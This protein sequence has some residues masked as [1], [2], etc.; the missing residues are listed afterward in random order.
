MRRSV[1]AIAWLLMLTLN[2]WLTPA[3][4][5]DATP[6]AAMPSA[7]CAMSTE[8]QN[9]KVAR[10]WYDVWGSEDSAV[11]EDIVQ[12]DII[13]HGGVG[14]DASNVVDLRARSD[15]FAVAFPDL[16]LVVEQVI[17]DGDYVA[18]RWIA[19][20][21]QDGPF[22]D[23]EPSGVE[24][25]WTGINIF[26]FECGKIAENWNEFDVVGLQAQLTGM[27]DPI[28]GTLATPAADATP[29]AGCAPTT[30]QDVADVAARWGDLWD[31]GDINVFDELASPDSVHHWGLG[32]DTTSLADFKDRIGTLFAGFSDL[33]QTNE[34]PIVDGDL[35]AIRWTMTGTQ[36]GP[37]FGFAPTGAEVTWTGINIFRV[38]C[39]QIVESWSEV[40]SLGL[41]SQLEAA[42]ST[43]TPAA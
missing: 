8:E 22:F 24:A 18:V 40:D 9:V 2:V 33:R 6:G 21:T 28:V 17:A 1:V 10:Q 30:E 42:S 41:K 35:V 39:G 12:P 29:A 7:N 16:S 15:V 31:E 23:I 38:A 25:T 26:R 19:T 36:D 5:Q 14:E 3:N 34:E 20:G 11:F 27:T 43:A 4:A 37:I 32:Q 13:H